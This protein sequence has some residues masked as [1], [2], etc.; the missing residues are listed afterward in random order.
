MD[1]IAHRSNTRNRSGQAIVEFIVGLVAVLAL[2]AGILQ[3]ASL[4][5]THTD[6][7]IEARRRAAELAMSDLPRGTDIHSNPEW[8]R[9]WRIGPDGRPHTRDDVPVPGNPDEFRSIVVQRAAP[10]EDWN[11][12]HEIPNN[13]LVRLHGAHDPGNLFGL[14]RGHDSQSVPLIPAARHLFYNAE[15]IDVQA[16]AWIPWLKGLY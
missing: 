13:R 9:T 15:S 12:M 1:S 3:V 2:L 7:I 8:L 14:V 5:K 6:T 11:L 10:S 16:E 4:T